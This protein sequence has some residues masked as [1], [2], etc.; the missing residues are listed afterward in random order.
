MRQ[1]F[2]TASTPS[3]AQGGVSI[4]TVGAWS[5]PQG[6]RCSL[7]AGGLPL[8]RRPKKKSFGME[9][10]YGQHRKC[11]TCICHRQHDTTFLGWGIPYKPSLTCCW[12]GSF[13]GEYLLA[14]W[15]C[16]AHRLGWNKSELMRSMRS[17]RAVF[18]V[19][20]ASFL[21]PLPETHSKSSI[22]KSLV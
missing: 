12:K 4:S 1:T 10:L 8:A 21:L 18:P 11:F 22:C 17:D 6:E 7:K 19:S 20:G 13:P 3:F 14:T 2:A 5:L 15:F 16:F 9:C